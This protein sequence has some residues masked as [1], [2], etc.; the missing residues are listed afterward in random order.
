MAIRFCLNDII[1]YAFSQEDDSDINFSLTQEQLELFQKILKEEIQ[2]HYNENHNYRYV[3]FDWDAHDVDIF[4]KNSKIFFWSNGICCI[5][6][7]PPKVAE[8]IEK[9]YS[10]INI[11]NAL[12][13]A[14]HKAKTLYDFI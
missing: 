5:N 10:D 1:Y 2:K 4:L 3:Y 9:H 6:L 14:R 7:I 11:V 12:R 13:K 8:K